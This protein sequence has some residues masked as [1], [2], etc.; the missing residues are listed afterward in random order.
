MA[1][2][3]EEWFG[4]EYLELYPHRD[5]DEA[6]RL[7]NLI[8]RELPWQDGWR[9]LDAAC[10]AGRHL[11][12]LEQAGAHPVGF[13]LS[14]A[15]LRRAREG[16]RR[17]LVRADLR[18]LPFRPGSMDLA[19]NLFT[20]FGYFSTDLEHVEAL[21]EMLDT[22][23]DDGWFVIDFLHPD[24]VRA[25]LVASEVSTMGRRTIEIT[26]SVSDDGRHVRKRIMLEGGRQFEERVRLFEAKE[27][28]QM[29]QELGARVTHRFGDYDGRPLGEGSRT[30]LFAQV[31]R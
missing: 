4:E 24:W 3:F 17:P 14:A 26:R 30:I 12:A 19:V 1:E 27:L 7:V 29:L 10:G 6:A 18:Y 11:K 28:E 31:T 2:W 13:D 25:N 22:V 16:T 8:R 20:S 9:V 21:A 23:R 15:L 5:S